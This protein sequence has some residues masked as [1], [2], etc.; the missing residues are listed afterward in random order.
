MLG[1]A[2][3]NY[4][5]LIGNAAVIAGGYPYPV[6]EQHAIGIRGDRIAAIGPAERFAEAVAARSIDAHGMFAFPGLANTHTHLF[7]TL[8]K[9][10]GDEMYLI[11]WVAATT[12]PTAL[13]L[14]PEEAY[15]GAVL[16]CIEAIRS[17]TTSILDF[18]YPS[19]RLEIFDRNLAGLPGDRHS[20]LPRSR[21]VHGRSVRFGRQRA[22]AA[23]D[24]VFANIRD[25]IQRYPS[26]LPTSERTP[27]PRRRWARWTAQG[28]LAVRQFAD[29]DGV[30]ITMHI[31][32]IVEDNPLSVQLH[33]KRSLPFLEDIGF[34]GPDVVAAHCVQLDAEDIA[35][36]AR[37]GTHVS[38]NP[39]SN[40]YLGNGIA[41]IVELL[42]AGA[43]VSLATDGAPATTAR[44]CSRR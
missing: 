33:G 20:R 6:L 7:Q 32:E 25:L 38:Y 10:L 43:A 16:G 3:R 35:I 2:T 42:R 15:L 28:F 21:P 34:L 39:V 44:T 27:R 19:R 29:S 17:G 12:L 8:L 40:F 11:P 22:G 36:L 37:T 26:R 13:A 23:L 4:D 14:D 5:L 31:N 18:A 9:G 30:R 41:P 1:R 24:E